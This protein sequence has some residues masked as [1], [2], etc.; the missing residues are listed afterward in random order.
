MSIVKLIIYILL[1]TEHS[2]TI[3]AATETVIFKTSTLSIKPLL[4]AMVPIQPCW[5]D[6]YPDIVQNNCA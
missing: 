3:S 1:K 6:M 4:D 5:P 2:L